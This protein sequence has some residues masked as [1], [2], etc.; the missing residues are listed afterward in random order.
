MRQLAIC[1]LFAAAL[2]PVQALPSTSDFEF[3]CGPYRYVDLPKLDYR[4]KDA[5]AEGQKSVWNLNHY[6]T[7]P[8]REELRKA[9]PYALAVI[10]NL[11]FSL[12]HSPNHH[13]AIQLLIEYKRRGGN[14]LQFPN[15]DC[16]L[17]WAHRFAPDDPVV[18]GY[19]GTYFA[20]TGNVERAEAWY[21]AATELDPMSAE[22]H[23]NLGLLYLQTKRYELARE[24]ARLAYSMGYP[25]PGLRDMLA[26]KGYAL[27][28]R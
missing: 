2:F 26:K 24:Q 23:Y 11:D 27:E 8:A 5:T 10:G 21:V 20:K 16:Y 25:L 22:T 3:G 6:H 28:G 13:E 4:L 7:D 14:F 9:Q 12:R 15:V 17:E 1:L 19:G 18:L